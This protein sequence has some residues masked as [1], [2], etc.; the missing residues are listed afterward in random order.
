MDKVSKF[1]NERFWIHVQFLPVILTALSGSD[2]VNRLA[3]PPLPPL[4]TP[5]LS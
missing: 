5:V 2:E 3:I 1:Y 4:L